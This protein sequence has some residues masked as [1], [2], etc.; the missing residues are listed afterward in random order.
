MDKQEYLGFIA[1]LE[2]ARNSLKA[3][4]RDVSPADRVT[5]QLT[6]IMV[7]LDKAIQAYREKSNA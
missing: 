3:V 7:D 2:N 1:I 4:V 5:P 6:R